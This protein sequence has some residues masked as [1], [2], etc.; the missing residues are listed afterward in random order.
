MEDWKLKNITPEFGRIFATSKDGNYVLASSS[1]NNNVY[2]LYKNIGNVSIKKYAFYDNIF[3]FKTGV[4]SS[5]C[6]ENNFLYYA[7]TSDF[8]SIYKYDI[9]NKGY[10]NIANI[11]STQNSTFIAIKVKG[12]KVYTLHKETGNPNSIFKEYVLSSGIYTYITG[13]TGFN[14]NIKDFDVQNTDNNY[15]IATI[16]ETINSRVLTLYK[17]LPNNQYLITYTVSGKLT[18]SSKLFYNSVTISENSEEIISGCITSSSSSRDLYIL[19]VKNPLD[20]FFSK[21]S[22]FYPDALNSIYGNTTNTTDKIIEVKFLLDNTTLFVNDNNTHCWIYNKKTN[23]NLWEVKGNY[24]DQTNIYPFIALNEMNYFKELGGYYEFRSTEYPFRNVNWTKDTYINTSILRGTVV[25]DSFGKNVQTSINGS[26]LS[27]TAN[28]KT[29]DL[30]IFKVDPKDISSYSLLN[31]LTSVLDHSFGFLDD[32]SLFYID[33]NFNL[34]ISFGPLFSN[35]AYT[36]SFGS[37]VSRKAVSYGNNIFVYWETPGGKF[38][39]YINQSFT[40]TDIPLSHIIPFTYNIPEIEVNSQMIVLSYISTNTNDLNKF[41]SYRYNNQVLSSLT[42]FSL[43]YDLVQSF[44]LARDENILY[45]VNRKNLNVYTYTTFW[46]LKSTVSLYLDNQP[47]IKLSLSTTNDGSIIA[48]GN[49]EKVRFYLFDGL[50]L[51]VY[52]NEILGDYIEDNFGNKVSFI[53]NTEDIIVSSPS[54]SSNYFSSGRINFYTSTP[55][56]SI[57]ESIFPPG[58]YDSGEYHFQRD[59]LNPFGAHIKYVY[60]R[61]S[62]DTW[63]KI[64]TFNDNATGT[65]GALFI[66]NGNPDRFNLGSQFSSYP[67]YVDIDT[68]NIYKNGILIENNNIANVKWGNVPPEE[69]LLSTFY[70][71]DYYV[72]RKRGALYGPYTDFSWKNS[73]I[74]VLPESFKS[75]NKFYVKHNFII[76]QN[77]DLFN[78]PNIVID[79]VNNTIYGPTEND[80]NI[81]PRRVII[82]DYV[83]PTKSIGFIGEYL[84]SSSLR[85][86]YGPKTLNNWPDNNVALPLIFD[87]ENNI[88]MF[89][90]SKESLSPS[91]LITSNNIFVDLLRNKI[92]K[93]PDNVSSNISTLNLFRRVLIGGGPPTSNIGLTGDY[94]ID[95]FTYQ[96]YGPLLSNNVWESLNNPII[97]YWPEPRL[98]NLPIYLTDS[99]VESAFINEESFCVINTSTNMIYIKTLD[100][101]QKINLISN[102]FPRYPTSIPSDYSDSF[103]LNS[104]TL[105]NP[106]LI[107][108]FSP[109]ETR[110]KFVD[111]PNKK[112]KTIFLVG[113]NITSDRLICYLNLGTKELFEGPKNSEGK[114]GDYFIEYIRSLD[115][116]IL[117]GP[118]ANDKWSFI[119]SLATTQTR[120]TLAS[121]NSTFDPSKFYLDTVNYGIIYPTFNRSLEVSPIK[122]PKSYS[123]NANILNVFPTSSNTTVGVPTYYTGDGRFYYRASFN[124]SPVALPII[125]KAV[126]VDRT[127]DLS[128]YRYSFTIHNNNLYS[129]F[130]QSLITKIPS[131]FDLKGDVIIS[132]FSDR[133]FLENNIV[134]NDIVYFSD[135]NTFYYFPTPTATI[136]TQIPIPIKTYFNLNYPPGFI[137]DAQAPVYILSGYPGNY[138]DLL[139]KKGQD[140]IKLNRNLIKYPFNV[141]DNVYI[142]K[143]NKISLE[144]FSANDIVLFLDINS[145]VQSENTSASGYSVSFL[146]IPNST[147]KVK[148][149]ANSPVSATLISDGKFFFPNANLEKI[150]NIKIK[151]INNGYIVVSVMYEDDRYNFVQVFFFNESVN[152]LCKIGDPVKA[153]LNL[154]VGNKP[155][156]K[157]KDFLKLSP[158]ERAAS[159]RKVKTVTNSVFNF[160]TG[161]IEAVT[162]DIIEDKFGAILSSAGISK[163]SLRNFVSTTIVNGNRLIENGFQGLANMIFDLDE[164]G[165]GSFGEDTYYLEKYNLLYIGAPTSYLDKRGTVR[166]TRVLNNNT[167]LWLEGN[168]DIGRFGTSIAVGGI[169]GEVLAVGQSGSF[170]SD[171]VGIVKVYE[172]NSDNLFIYRKQNKGFPVMNIIKNTL[173]AATTGAL[174]SLSVA[175]I[176]LPIVGVLVAPLGGIGLIFL[177]LIG[178]AI[179]AIVSLIGEIWDGTFDEWVT[180]EGEGQL[181]HTGGDIVLSQDGQTLVVSEIRRPAVMDNKIKE[182]SSREKSYDFISKF[183]ETISITQNLTKLFS[184]KDQSVVQT[185]IKDAKAA[186]GAG[187]KTVLAVNFA[188]YIKRAQAYKKILLSSAKELGKIALSSGQKATLL[189]SSAK[190]A[191]FLKIKNVVSKLTKAAAGVDFAVSVLFLGDS[192]QSAVSFGKLIDRI[193]RDLDADKFSSINLYSKDDNWKPS[194][195]LIDNTMKVMIDSYISRGSSNIQDSN[196]KSVVNDAVQNPNK[197]NVYSPALFTGKSMFGYGSSVG[198]SGDGS[199]LASIDKLYMNDSPKNLIQRATSLFT[200]D[201]VETIPSTFTDYK[202]I[203]YKRKF[204][205]SRSFYYWQESSKQI[206]EKLTTEQP[207]Q[208]Y[209]QTLKLSQ[210]GKYLAVGSPFYSVRD[211]ILKG[212]I[213]VYQINNDPIKL[214]SIEGVSEYQIVGQNISFETNGSA[215]SLIVSEFDEELDINGNPTDS[216]SVKYNKFI[217]NS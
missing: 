26:Y 156:D 45:V 34:K 131:L 40:R 193:D 161:V 211:Q 77:A 158:K 128:E 93:G 100:P 25:N 113:Y 37:S 206:E 20:T 117:V 75:V 148:P 63:E 35:T 61:S 67:Y 114:N 4:F 135:L 101:D 187:S 197:Y 200:E 38:I 7:S 52:G 183:G 8:G 170:I 137:S 142:V 204:D 80:I 82:K 91:T 191:K 54:N 213:V 153:V 78:T 132:T 205:N 27:V 194:K 111:K 2:N 182:K 202:I 74:F 171:T 157:V 172:K 73:K 68:R 30:N 146:Q 42:E 106:N 212:R 109:S 168:R 103:I 31:R 119:S 44:T 18:S 41:Y 39:T 19:S 160:F 96:I 28:G 81:L 17:S 24:F 22:H 84:Y 13:F 151:H 186:S 58:I 145:F 118:K 164:G 64:L 149:Y 5:A 51:N 162:P 53:R 3:N 47:F 108:N 79:P 215:V 116:Y 208:D 71:G 76:S 141:S 124:V 12:S 16:H 154:P 86:L 90:G 139:Q 69:Y 110:I 89:V 175:G 72:D 88:E 98:L 166:I 99:L 6:I 123:T 144:D 23:T 97:G 1:T 203:I 209:S 60:K 46:E 94:Y 167:L 133:S 169:H 10:N 165:E 115:K 181:F 201:D 190:T 198:I 70:P 102:P 130:N 43:P 134:K 36:F 59:Y 192:I 83:K 92:Y 176:I 184:P 105:F 121:P 87:I 199:T 32:N 159:E 21:R 173:R 216:F 178:V 125:E 56:F 14:I 155:K 48:I 55:L 136:L 189:A 140:L 29:G 179:A 163:D 210:D 33:S 214:F 150:K 49:G 104:E 95:Q 9:K 147:L 196:L 217:L 185:G 126:L 62:K 85:K 143:N 152:Y 180:V 122:F 66:G 11:S 195:K 57:N 188:T 174:I 177:V 127:E 138:W 65:G 50:F 120:F 112:V 15:T 207:V 129:K 107:Y